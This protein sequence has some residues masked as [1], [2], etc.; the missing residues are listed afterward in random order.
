MCRACPHHCRALLLHAPAS[1]PCLCALQKWTPEL[2]LSLTRS[3]SPLLASSRSVLAQQLPP[4]MSV[5]RASTIT[6]PLPLAFLCS[7]RQYLCYPQFA[8]PPLPR[9]LHSPPLLLFA[10]VATRATSAVGSGAMARRAT[11]YSWPCYWPGM[12]VAKPGQPLP[13]TVG[14]H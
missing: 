10:G 8:P 1:L 4:W 7:S 3:P 12:V 2:P 5:A 6:V 11:G 14:S 13:A 9:Q